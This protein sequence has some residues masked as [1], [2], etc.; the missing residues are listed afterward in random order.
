MDIRD[1]IT[2]PGQEARHGAVPAWLAGSPVWPA[3]KAQTGG[4]QLYLHQDMGL[5]LLGQGHNLVIST[6]TASGKSL[7]FQAPTLHHLATHPN[8][9][10]IAI[11]PIKA[12][13]RDQVVRWRNLAEATGLD[14]ESINRIDGDVRDLTE[15]RQ[16][17]Q[18]TRLALMTPDVIQQWLMAYSEA[19]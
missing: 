17:L 16:I 10:A 5:E 11:Y 13:A 15:R 8:A 14:P 12:L 3:V 1:E 4:G 18:R 6:G 19:L 2:I 9:T 7:V